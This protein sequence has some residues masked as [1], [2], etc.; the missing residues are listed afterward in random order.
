MAKKKAAAKPRK[1]K[2]PT[3]GMPKKGVPA[4]VLAPKK[5]A[6]I[7][8]EHEK[9][10]QEI[11][12]NQQIKDQ[13]LTV[14]EQSAAGHLMELAMVFM[15]LR[16]AVVNRSGKAARLSLLFKNGLI[17]EL[18]SLDDVEI[19]DRMK[20]RAMLRKMLGLRS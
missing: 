9:A 15:E 10:I 2:Q 3:A 12:F 18:L 17:D 20:F 19:I 14:L 11:R 1:Q 8:P 13:V 4:A 7:S 5:I 16:L 6:P